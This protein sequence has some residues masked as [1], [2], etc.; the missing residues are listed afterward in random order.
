MAGESQ[1]IRLITRA[2]DIGAA[3]SVNRAVRDIHLHGVLRNAGVMAC[4][5]YAA[6]AVDVFA[7]CP[8]L[9]IGMHTCLNCEW[10]QPLW[11]PVAPPEKVPDLLDEHGALT[12]HPQ[13]LHDRNV[14]VEQMMI[15]VRAQLDRLRGL[16]FDLKYL[17]EHMAVGWVNGLEEALEDLRAREGLVNGRTFDRLPPVENP[18]EDLLERVAAEVRAA[19][20]GLY[21]I[22]GHPWYVEPETEAFAYREGAPGAQ[23]KPRDAQRRIFCAPD[24]LAVYEECGVQPTRIDEAK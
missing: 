9:C 3:R 23:A 13:I 6:E 8:D 19:P 16:G 18:P 5:P 7:D 11:S 1:P 2:D 10:A 4:A 21:M 14:D 17:D 12:A 24:L 15:E 20:P 22:V